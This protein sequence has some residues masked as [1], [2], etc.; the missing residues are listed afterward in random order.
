MSDLLAV[1][2]YPDKARGA[3]IEFTWLSAAGLDSPTPQRGIARIDK[4]QAEQVAK[5]HASAIFVYAPM[6]A[7]RQELPGKQTQSPA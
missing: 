5:T 1:C 4:R 3:G 6:M 2:D 7:Q